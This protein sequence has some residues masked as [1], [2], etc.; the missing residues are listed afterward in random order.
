LLERQRRHHLTFHKKELTVPLLALALA[1][2]LSACGGERADR[3]PSTPVSSPLGFTAL[4][5]DVFERSGCVS[6][7]TIQ[8]VSSATIGPELTHVG[9]Y[10]EQRRPGLAVEDYIRQS[11]LDPNAYVVPGYQ[12]VMPSGLAS[13]ISDEDFEAL[14]V[15]LVSLK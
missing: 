10:A 3:T 8:G 5:E 14:I 13:M 2:A 12:P 4:G 15:Y 9:S 11:I 6:C 7:H 1:L